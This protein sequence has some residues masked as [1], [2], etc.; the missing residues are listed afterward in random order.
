VVELLSAI[1]FYMWYSHDRTGQLQRWCDRA[2]AAA[3]DHLP[4]GIRAR[5][6]FAVGF[7][8]ADRGE[9][10]RHDH[11]ALALFR[12][13]DDDTMVARCLV[14]LAMTARFDPA[15]AGTYAEEAVQHARRAADDGLIGAALGEL[16]G[17]THSIEAAAPL[18]RAAV[19]LLRAA[20]AHELAAQVLSEL[21]LI[22]ALEDM[23][24]TVDQLGR[25]AEESAAAVG[26]TW[27]VAYVQGNV[28]AAA[29]LGDRH[30]AAR[31]G[32][33]D[34][35]M[36]AVAHG[37]PAFSRFDPLYGMAAL[38][39][40]AGDDRRAAVLAGAASAIDA[41]PVSPAARPVYNR[42]EQRFLAPARERLGDKEWGRRVPKEGAWSPTQQWRTH[43]SRRSRRTESGS[44]AAEAD[45][46]AL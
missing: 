21:C 16:S 41:L 1:A 6:E 43:S 18:A 2:L 31:A 25:E 9:R 10:F 24:D 5:A 8:S 17:S 40:A 14:D 29:L 20:D 12:E 42:L 38:A 37:L 7:N 28:A 30:D 44:N 4:L 39:G 26:D 19:K 32:F 13:L 11:A 15:R 27:T 36:T 3:G 33:E 23:H 45:D 22:A 46:M 34:E 35:L